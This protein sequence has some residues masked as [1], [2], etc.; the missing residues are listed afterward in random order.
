ME[1]NTITTKSPAGESTATTTTTNQLPEKVRMQK[2]KRKRG[3]A[4]RKRMTSNFLQKAAPSS[5]TIHQTYKH[6]LEIKPKKARQSIKAN[7][8]HVKQIPLKTVNKN[9][10]KGKLMETNWG[11]KTVGEKEYTWEEAVSI[12][13]FKTVDSTNEKF[14][15][16]FDQSE[17]SLRIFA[18][19]STQFA[20]QRLGRP[21]TIE[22]TRMFAGEIVEAKPKIGQGTKC[23]SGNNGYAIIGM[24]PN[25]L[26]SGNGVYVFK[27]NVDPTT[28]DHLEL[29]ALHIV[30]EMQL[31]L[32]PMAKFVNLEMTVMNEVVSRTT[33]NAIDHHTTAFS[34]GKDYHSKCHIDANMF[35]T[36]L[37]VIAPKH[38]S[39]DEVIY[40][41]VFPTYEVKVPL[42]SGDTLL[43]N[44]S[45][46]HSCSNPK[47]EGCY[48]TSAYV[49]RKT[50]LTANPL[51]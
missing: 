44:P 47:Y 18:K 8:Q 35:Y 11:W 29:T 36:R 38:V 34:I 19:A 48:I 7:L 51:Q 4:C 15:L 28:Q 13:S 49:S 20:K 6:L 43:F 24:R 30:K 25:Q 50:V 9:G 17:L 45:V 16:A 26:T 42:K 37:T 32:S 2:A 33:L 5:S 23:D 10:F 22:I 31:C 1:A 12:E 21:K 14:I 39:E 27:N 41:F 3:R 46:Y 40:Y